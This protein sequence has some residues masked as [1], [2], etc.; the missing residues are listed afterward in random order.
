MREERTRS[1][2]IKQKV[3]ERH[4]SRIDVVVVVF[5]VIGKLCVPRKER[6][7]LARHVFCVTDGL[8]DR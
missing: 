3:H 8:P 7:A 2:E 4:E 1:G 5:F 6:D